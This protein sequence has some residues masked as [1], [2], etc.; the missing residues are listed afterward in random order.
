[1]IECICTDCP[2]V[3]NE[4][5]PQLG[6]GDDNDNGDRC[7]LNVLEMVETEHGIPLFY[8]TYSDM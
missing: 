2:L 4:D 6:G 5:P 7:C 8:N 1:M 3:H